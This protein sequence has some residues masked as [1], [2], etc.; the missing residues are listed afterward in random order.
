MAD[1]QPEIGDTHIAPIR[2]SGFAQTAHQGK[3]ML[4]L[5]PKFGL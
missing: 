4:L 2:E 5:V 3:Q 1:M